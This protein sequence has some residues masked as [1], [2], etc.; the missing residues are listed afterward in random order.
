MGR[1]YTTYLEY[2]KSRRYDEVR[3]EPVLSESFYEFE[4]PEPVKYALESMYEIDPSY[5]YKLFSEVRKTQEFITDKLSQRDIHVDA[6]YQ[7]PHN[8]DVHIQLLGD[9]ELVVVLK[10]KSE[11]PSVDVER[12]FNEIID[13]LGRTM[14][15]DKIDSASRNRIYIQTKKPTCD[16]SILPSIWVDSKT[17]INTG[18]EIN[19]GI[20]EYNFEKKTKKVHLPF[21]N[22]ARINARDRDLKGNMKYIFR[23]LRSLIQDS[24]REIN[25]GFDEISGILYN[26]PEKYFMVPKEK[27]LSILP[28]VSVQL[29]RLITK[30]IYRIKLLA[31][32]QKEYVFSK[33]PVKKSLLNLKK[34]LDTLI[35]D[36]N[37]SLKDYD[38][39]IKN[40][41]EYF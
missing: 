5:S 38:L 11:K 28:V 32:S 23:L 26:I 9:I 22:M 18:L 7:G 13:I 2:L 21:L 4:Y 25:L 27:L 36:I 8:C 34:E 33:R 10:D 35:I 14:S 15:Y 3:K 12:L 29:K 1:D 39:T 30:D 19:R 16:I 6:R 24:E 37:K 40:D 41:I 17:Y 31:P 20:C